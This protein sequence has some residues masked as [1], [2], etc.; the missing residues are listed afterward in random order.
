MYAL[1]HKKRKAKF[2]IRI[3][4]WVFIWLIVVVIVLAAEDG[5]SVFEEFKYLWK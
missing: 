3:P 4:V 5:N 2:M 1:H